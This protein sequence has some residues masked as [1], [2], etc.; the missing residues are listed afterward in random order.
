VYEGDDKTLGAEE[1]LPP[2]IVTPIEA[3]TN[4]EE[5]EEQSGESPPNYISIT[6]SE[7]AAIPPWNCGHFMG[8]PAIQPFFE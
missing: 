6:E 3:E 1:T 5:S 4:P 2:D 8:D 7:Q